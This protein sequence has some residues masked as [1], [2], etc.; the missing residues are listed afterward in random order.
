MIRPVR[1]ER[2]AITAV[3]AANG[4]LFGA[5][6]SGM[7]EIKRGLDLDDGEFGAALVA[8]PVGL[9][10]A[11]PLTAALIGRRG[12]ASITRLA[13]LA[14]P[15]AFIL[16]ALAPS[17][18]VLVMTL[19]A[20]GYVNGSLDVAMNA[21]GVEVERALGTRLF[22]SLHAAFSFGGLAGAG[23]SA[24]VAA[25]GVGLEPGLVLV[26]AVV[27]AIAAGVWR[28]LVPDAPREPSPLF[29]VPPRAVI[30]LGVIAFCTL[31]A[32]GAIADWSA[33]YLRETL[34][35]GAAT[36]ALGLAAFS[37][38]MGA[39]RL[40]SDRAA[41]AW[42]SER[43]VRAGAATTIGGIALVVAAQ[44]PAAAIT[45]FAVAGLGLSSLFP[46]A[47]RAA[48]AREELSVGAAIAG[49]ATTGYVGFLAGPALIGF[50]SQA[51]S[52]RTALL[53]LAALSA[54]TLVLAGAA[55]D[56]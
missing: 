20:V 42:G 28:T 49:V 31:M 52:L 54:C 3:F 39:G 18:A 5:L 53:L 34:E 21:Q 33:V 10:I 32:E 27:L 46:L 38:A 29:A 23:T 16:P 56:R 25:A 14:S 40:V 13:L 36:A 15:F 43:L 47:L 24:A 30:V 9:L 50:V 12:S 17:Y 37:L 7:A 2:I 6:F 35:A 1:P 19:F 22:G 45:G 41:E 51:S 4:F 26:A 11:Q 44:A 8:L 48:A 55:R